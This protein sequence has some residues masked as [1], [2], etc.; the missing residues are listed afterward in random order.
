MATFPPSHSSSFS[1]RILYGN[2]H[3]YRVFSQLHWFSFLAFFFGES[4]LG[5]GYGCTVEKD[6]YCVLY[7]TMLV[8][9]QL[10]RLYSD[11]FA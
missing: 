7:I 11:R 3:N 6:I 8:L 1:L 10:D 9:R 5:D 4:A 2:Q